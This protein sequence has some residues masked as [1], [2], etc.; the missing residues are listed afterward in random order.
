MADN[1]EDYSLSFEG[2]D[3]EAL[4]QI[5][6]KT[7]CGRVEITDS[8][9]RTG[10][11]YTAYRYETTITDSRLSLMSNPVCIVTADRGVDTSG[12]KSKPSPICVGLVNTDAGT[13]TLKIFIYSGTDSRWEVADYNPGFINF[14]V[15][16]ANI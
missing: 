4:L 11:S 9:Y 14:I 15:M 1:I 8:M 10:S 13:L 16:E 5:L 3:V 6:K 2:A 12:S 7:I